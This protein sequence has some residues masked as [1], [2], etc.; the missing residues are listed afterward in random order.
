MV[1]W[2]CFLIATAASGLSAF[3]DRD[4]NV[5]TNPKRVL[6]GDPFEL[7]CSYEPCRGEGNH[8]LLSSDRHK[9]D[10]VHVDNFTI[11]H[12]V[13]KT[14][15]EGGIMIF[16]CVNDRT[17]LS[18]AIEVRPKLNVK[19]FECISRGD[20]LVAECIFSQLVFRGFWESIKYYLSIDGGENHQCQ[21][22]GNRIQCSNQYLLTDTEM[23]N[24]TFTLEMRF[25]YTLQRQIF[26]F[27]RAEIKVPH[28]P[29]SPPIVSQ[30]PG[31]LTCVDFGSYAYYDRYEW[32]LMLFPQ[33]PRVG[34]EKELRPIHRRLLRGM[35]E[36][37]FKTP[38]YYNQT[39][40]VHLWRRYTSE[41]NNNAW[42]RDF[43]AVKFTTDTYRP[44]RP[45]Y[46]LSDV[47]YYET[48]T[49]YLHVFWHHMFS[50]EFGD[51]DLTYI[52]RTDTS[53][54]ALHTGEGSAIFDK[55]EPTHPAT[56]LVWSKNSV[57]QSENSSKLIVPVLANFE[58]H[59]AQDLW[60]HKENQTMTWKP[61]KDVNKLISYIVIWCFVSSNITFICEDQK[62]IQS[63]PV[64]ASMQTFQFKT[65]AADLNKA[66]VA[67][68][69]D[70]SSGGMV[71]NGPSFTDSTTGE[72]KS[73]G[74]EEIFYIGG[75]VAVAFLPIIAALFRK[76]KKMSQIDIVFPVGLFDCTEVKNELT[77][78]SAP[79]TI[80]GSVPPRGIVN[81]KITMMKI[82]PEEDLKVPSS[83]VT[84]NEPSIES[85]LYVPTREPD[86]AP[87][88]YVATEKPIVVSMSYV[89]VDNTTLRERTVRLS[90]E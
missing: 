18:R 25:G 72:S 55:W 56:V 28:W 21:S 88:S 52:V 54:K 67:L 82:I 19:D 90:Y 80:P 23:P 84:M 46:L 8:F 5:Y 40:V 74:S 22:M 4:L 12:R 87:S 47:F 63:E 3:C 2:T 41:N 70:G 85:S 13:T 15:P 58:L 34:L 75:S 1:W 76:L 6:S 30:K 53:K 33:N 14:P 64:P 48:D 77:Q 71:W 86:I 17:Q 38:H 51:S 65:Q 61:P 20:I 79:I 37:C 32:K 50:L 60:Y 11:K 29:I 83:Y 66:V 7:I 57:G 69:E 68:Y 73:S 89:T 16:I 81:T 10:T 62:A 45:P 36:I 26:R 24:L 27:N 9:L 31:H 39:F 78:P 35:D 59:Q 44:G 49:K 42:T 43:Y